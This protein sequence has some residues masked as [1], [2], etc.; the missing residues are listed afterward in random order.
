MGTA[1]LEV[2]RR[3]AV[4]P[5]TVAPLAHLRLRWRSD[6][7]RVYDVLLAAPMVIAEGRAEIVLERLGSDE[8]LLDVGGTGAALVRVR[9]TPYWFAAGGCVERAGAWTRV[10]ARRRGFM[11]LSTRFAPERIL[12]HGRRCDDG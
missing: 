3:A 10:I 2:R 12:E 5:W 9:W 11:R 8:L 4:S 1:V 7:W 6:D